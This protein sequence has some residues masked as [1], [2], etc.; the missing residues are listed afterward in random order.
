MIDD[1]YTNGHFKQALFDQKKSKFD[2]TRWQ[3]L[4]E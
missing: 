1:T 4:P 3:R 2:M